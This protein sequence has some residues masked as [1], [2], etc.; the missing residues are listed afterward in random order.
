MRSH[1]FPVCEAY[2][3]NFE[4]KNFEEGDE[5]TYRD[6]GDGVLAVFNEES[7]FILLRLD[8]SGEYLIEDQESIPDGW[9]P[10]DS[11][12]V[13][14]YLKLK[15][16]RQAQNS[17]SEAVE[18]IGVDKNLRAGY[19][20]CI[21]IKPQTGDFY[22]DMDSFY[23]S[24]NN[25]VWRGIF[26]DTLFDLSFQPVPNRSNNQLDYPCFITVM[27]TGTRFV[28]LGSNNWF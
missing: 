6:F 12:G 5:S 16:T 15:N 4:I 26:S 1:V 22:N 21:G 2:F 25:E 13:E 10:A 7:G 24:L 23:I 18:K 14:I 19:V 8:N 28:I 17:Y 9:P 20:F 11:G 27:F 3:K